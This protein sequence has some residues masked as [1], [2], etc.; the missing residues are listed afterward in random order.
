MKK[1]GVPARAAFDE[2]LTSC[3]HPPNG[4]PARVGPHRAF[5]SGKFLSPLT[6]R[7]KSPAEAERG[8]LIASNGT[9]NRGCLR[10]QRPWAGR[11]PGPGSWRM[12]ILSGQGPLPSCQRAFLAGSRS[13]RAGRSSETS[14]KISS[15]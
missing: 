14:G 15:R 13:F 5:T 7:L 8:L 9:G 6:R 1:P 11:W 2:N 3:Q 10:G 4:I 12:P